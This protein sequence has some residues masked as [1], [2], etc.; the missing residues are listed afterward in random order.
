MSIN[1]S[2]NKNSIKKMK[3]DEADENV[4]S[5][6]EYKRLAFLKFYNENGKRS[7]QFNKLFITDDVHALS[8][9]CCFKLI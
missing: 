9:F 5:I 4:S 2:Q 8:I 6:A 3:L 7:I 1:H